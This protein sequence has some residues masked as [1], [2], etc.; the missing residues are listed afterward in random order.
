[1]ATLT[2]AEVAEKFGVSPREVR[3]LAHS[4]VLSGQK[5]G[6]ILVFDSTEV[7][8]LQR[9]RR[10]PGRLWSR[11]TAWA[12]LELVNGASTDLIDQPR[13]SRLVAKLRYLDAE[14][15]H[16]L[17]VNR[18]EV[19]RFHA[20]DRALPRLSRSLISTG[21]S[22]VADEAMARR[23]G[24][25]AV[26]SEKRV[27]GYFRGD[28]EELAQQCR[29]SPDPSG[30]VVVRLLPDGLAIDHLLGSIPVV[31]VDLMDSDEVRERGSG[32]NM[33]DGLLHGI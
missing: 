21:V 25:S 19:H 33:L 27:D 28:M 30:N 6:T 16:R 11:W 18:A 17:A 3:R 24:L 23:F 32:R 9:Q 12:A 22:A 31:A 7:Y 1:M 5:I 20:S 10:Q 8:R 4:G 29:L 13:R 15:F 2:T 26:T 14:Q